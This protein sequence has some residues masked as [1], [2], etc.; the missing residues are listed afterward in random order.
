MEQKGTSN[1][2]LAERPGYVTPAEACH[3]CLRARAGIQ[4]NCPPVTPVK[5]GVQN[6]R[7]ELDSRPSTSSGQALR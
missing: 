2:I 3:P 7:E 5:A 6:H 1:Q 4:E